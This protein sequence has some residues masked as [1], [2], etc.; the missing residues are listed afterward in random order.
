MKGRV[1]DRNLKESPSLI[2]PP[3]L[4]NP[5]PLPTL[6]AAVFH[7]PSLLPSRT[8]REGWGRAGAGVTAQLLRISVGRGLGATEVPHR[9]KK[10]ECRHRPGRFV[11]E[12][13]HSMF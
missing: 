2:Q 6:L 8:G 11:T 10:A 1:R 3:H 9:Q 4:C 7:M 5:L 12:I 13:K